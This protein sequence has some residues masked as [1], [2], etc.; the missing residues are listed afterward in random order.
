MKIKRQ[1]KR[2]NDCA[3]IGTA[4]LEYLRTHPKAT[5]IEIAKAVEKSR[6]T[7]QNT[8]AELKEKDLIEREG[9][10]MNAAGLSNR[11]ESPLHN[12]CVLDARPK[13][14]L[15]YDCVCKGYRII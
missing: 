10:R 6:R 14:G 1:S 2:N 15:A 9:A 11:N 7:V 12:I 13:E 8:I 3:L 4:V 5:Q